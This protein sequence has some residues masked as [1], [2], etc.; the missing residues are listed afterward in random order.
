MLLFFTQGKVQGPG[1][2]GLGKGRKLQDLMGGC[3]ALND[4][5][6]LKKSK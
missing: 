4:A 6:L 1:M 5:A 2:V 3:I